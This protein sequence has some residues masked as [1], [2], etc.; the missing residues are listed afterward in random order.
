[1]QRLFA[2]RPPGSPI[3]AKQSAIKL[4]NDHYG[5]SSGDAAVLQHAAGHIAHTEA[6]TGAEQPRWKPGAF[7]CRFAPESSIH[8][9]SVLRPC[10]RDAAL[11]MRARLRKILGTSPPYPP[12]PPHPLGRGYAPIPGG[13]EP[14]GRAA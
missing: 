5:H 1:M 12:F 3:A 7:E 6:S 13:V 9:D 10:D 2:V 8:L 14:P 4:Y 11:C